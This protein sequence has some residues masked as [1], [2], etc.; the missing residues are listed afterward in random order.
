MASRYLR[1]D[2]A[3]TGVLHLRGKQ[4]ERRETEGRRKGD[5]SDGQIVRIMGSGDSGDSGQ[6]GEL[7]YLVRV[8]NMKQPTC[9]HTRAFTHLHALYTS[10]Y[11]FLQSGERR[12]TDQ[13]GEIGPTVPITRITLGNRHKVYIISWQAAEE[14]RRGE[15]GKGGERSGT[16]KVS[17]T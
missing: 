5:G 8:L 2:A 6:W 1:C 16:V 4:E 7:Y 13:G 15:K 11:V 9:N 17:V 3:L 10:T 14:R 12:L